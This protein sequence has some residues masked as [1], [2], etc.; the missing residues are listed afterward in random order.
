[1]N[2]L[3]ER[4][5][6]IGALE[7]SLRELVAGRGGLV[8]VEAAA[9]I[10][11]TALLRHVRDTARAAGLIVLSARGAEL[12]RNFTFGAVRQLFEPV[13]PGTGPARR[14]LFT[15]AAAETERLFVA[16]DAPAT[17]SLHQ[18]L[19]GLYWLLVN[20]VAA[21]PAVVLVDDAQWVDVPSLRF[22]GFLARRLDSL[23]VTV[24]VAS[25]AG[26]RDDELLDDILGSGDATLLEPKGLSEAAVAELVRRTLGQDADAGFR[27]A[28]HAI[29]GGNPLFVRELLRILAAAGTRPDAAAVAAVEASGPNAVRRHLAA[30]LRRHPAAF[31]KVARAVAVLGDGTDLSLVA[32]QS[33]LTVSEAATAAEQLTRH[34]I[35]ERDD[36]PAFVHAVVRDVVLSLIPLAERSAEHKRAATVLADAALP[37]THVAA[38]LLRAT[39]EA[40]PDRIGVLVAAAS[41]AR[42]QGSPGNAAVF[43]LRARNEPPPPAL[44]SEVNRLLGN[45]LAHELAFADAEVHLREA[46]SCADSPAQWSL[47]AY[48]LARFRHVC[49]APGEAVALLIEAAKGLPTD[50][51]MTAEL[52]A[53]LIGIARN[54]IASRPQV[55]D[56]LAACRRLSRAPADVDAQLSLESVL[57]GAPVDDAVALARRALAGE[58][59]APDRSGIWAAVQTLVVADCLDEAD[60]RL[61]RALRTAVRQGLLLATAL[62]RGFLA[63]VAFLRGDLALAGEHVTQGMAGL[64]QP[65]VAVSVLR[66]VRVNLLI[67]DG[68]LT[69]A[70][71]IL[72]D[73]VLPDGH[74]PQTALELWLLEARIRL[75]AAQGRPRAALA[76]A[77]AGVRLYRQWGAARLL[78]VPWR[79][80]A[81]N[82]CARLG[83][84]DRAEAFVAEQLRQAQ[85][86]GIPRHIGMALCDAAGLAE[87]GAAARPLLH[88]AV[89]LLEQ[90]AARLELASALERLG[91]VLIDD[92]ARQDGRRAVG[93]AAELATECHATAMVE[94]LHAVLAGNGGPA[95]RTRLS[96]VRAFTPAER[97]VAELAATGLTNRQIAEQLFLSEKT[98]EAHLSRA[99]RKLGVR[100]RTQLAVHIATRFTPQH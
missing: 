92:G 17:D 91:T 100:S 12:E 42:R 52:E 65:T 4:D 83:H 43:L 18:L 28:C 20:L 81:A 35:L 47:C 77:M 45:C 86:F 89:E 55:R 29:T 82:A 38:H 30:R 94:R 80:H 46:L 37:A 59:L 74:E 76:D 93:R 7:L 1:V 98:V 87:T 10:G 78:D 79:R 73:S 88:E 21:T 64:A 85:S 84:R 90:S 70:D 71:D 22:L 9:G 53:E 99:Y 63:R 16:S 56:R 61:N 34:G 67:E 60:R 13:L 31:R 40:D 57:S 19:N 54:D 2:V 14:R 75:R 44:R 23:P 36:P 5:D 72:R 69:E 26:E 51:D 6:E 25:R 97:Q 95:H 39:P 68:L 66:A 15:G 27:T 8:F 41:H 11:K 96:G 50:A 48:S 3:L 24:V 58:R 49:G 62:L 33:D 32:R